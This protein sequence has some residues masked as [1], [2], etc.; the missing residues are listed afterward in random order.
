MTASAE[1]LDTTGACRYC[2]SAL[3]RV[4]HGWHCP[5]CHATEGEPEPAT[6]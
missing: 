3:L 5:A 4:I 6:R 1:T 2:R